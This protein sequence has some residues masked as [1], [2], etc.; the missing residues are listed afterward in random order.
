M[1]EAIEKHQSTENKIEDVSDNET[2]LDHLVRLTKGTPSSNSVC[3]QLA[4]H[5]ADRT[6][7]KDEILNILVAARDTVGICYS[8]RSSSA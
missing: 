2:F 4:Y 8:Y 3:D 6:V 5:L 7:L 1:E